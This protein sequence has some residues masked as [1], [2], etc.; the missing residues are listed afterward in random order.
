MQRATYPGTHSR[1]RAK[2]L[3]L[4]FVMA[5]STS[6]GAQTAR[7]TEAQANDWYARHPWPV[8]ANFLPSNA[9]NELVNSAGQNPSA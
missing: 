6:L 1:L 9:V 7:W 5:L 8:G 3:L 4:V 2:L